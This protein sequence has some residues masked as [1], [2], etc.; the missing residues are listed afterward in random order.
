MMRLYI[1]IQQDIPIS[2]WCNQWREII[3]RVYKYSQDT[4]YL[5]PIYTNIIKVLDEA[6][7]YNIGYNI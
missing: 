2:F 7:R 4:L 6:L 1:Y 3:A 5:C